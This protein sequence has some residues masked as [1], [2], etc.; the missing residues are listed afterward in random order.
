MTIYERYGFINQ[1]PV[2]LRDTG[3]GNAFHYAVRTESLFEET[4]P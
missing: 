3:H 1:T 4:S 2:E